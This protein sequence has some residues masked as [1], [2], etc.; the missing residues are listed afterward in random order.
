MALVLH[1]EVELLEELLL[2]GEVLDD[3][4]DH[5]V[6]VVQVV[7]VGGGGD[8]AEGR[9]ARR[10]RSSLPRSTCLASDF[11][12]PTPPWRRRVACLRDRSTTSWPALA[13]TSA[14]PEPMIPDPRMPTRLIV[15]GGQV[16]ER[17]PDGSKSRR[18]VRARRRPAPAR[19][20]AM[21]GLSP[22]SVVVSSPTAA[23]SIAG[24]LERERRR[25]GARAADRRGLRAP[26]A[27]SSSR[28][29]RWFDGARRHRPV[30]STCS[31]ARD[32]L[33]E[34]NV[35]AVRRRRGSSTSSAARRCTCARC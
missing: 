34:A 2:H 8:P 4:L 11:S 3:R 1:D 17:Y 9:L 26:P 15:M 24:L 22:W 14:M 27:R 12:R 28:P 7:E 25:R 21:P 5:E 32:A 6:A 10:P 33:D 16:T 31:A 20:G 13:A 35:E 18:S 23:P 19:V 29:S 30:A